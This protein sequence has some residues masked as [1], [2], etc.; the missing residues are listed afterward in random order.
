MVS[1]SE[2]HGLKK[3]REIAQIDSMDIQ[4]RT[5]L[6]NAL[7]LH[8]WDRYNW[9]KQDFTKFIWMNYFKAPIDEISEYESRNLERIKN[10]FFQ[11]P[12]NEVY[13]FTEFMV[14]Y[15][16]Y[17]E[18]NKDFIKTCNIILERE[19]SAYRFVGK[20]I[21]KNISTTEISEVEEAMET[22][23]G[24]VNAHVEQAIKLLSDR[25]TPDYRNSIKE[26][27]S[28]VEAICRILVNNKNAPLGQALGV[29]EKHIE[30]HG[31]LRRSFESLYGYTSSA[32]GIRHSL[33]EKDVTLSYEDAK[34]MLVS[35][36]A[37]V[38]YLVSKAAKANIKI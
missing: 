38:N 6:W 17:E 31:A 15:S 18:T 19:A 30:I 28:A 22:P 33:L 29:I 12:W 32:E 11:C 23:L 1:F 37:F 4:L 14:Q 27:I 36:S 35:C 20:Q 10:Y 5:C 13:D 25:T 2:R 34:F 7:T 26:S 8:Y 24:V 21:M 9:R 3:K 16:E